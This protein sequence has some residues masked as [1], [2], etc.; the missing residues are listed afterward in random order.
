MKTFFY[1]LSLCTLLSLSIIGFLGVPFILSSMAIGSA[2]LP[3]EEMA[4]TWFYCLVIAT[5]YAILGLLW[6]LFFVAF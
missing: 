1:A 2:I 4:P 5:P 6:R 3:A